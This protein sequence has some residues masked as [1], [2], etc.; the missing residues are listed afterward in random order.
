MSDTHNEPAAKT[1]ELSRFYPPRLIP[2]ETDEGGA[3]IAVRVRRMRR[4]EF[5]RVFA[6]EWAGLDDE[7][8][9]SLR[10]IYRKPDTDERERLD[11]GTGAYVVPD[12]VIRERRL[13][14]MSADEREAF[15]KLEAREAEEAA[16][17][18]ARAVETYVEVAPALP[19]GTRQRVIID[20]REIRTGADLVDVFGGSLPILSALAGLVRQEHQIAPDEKKGWRSRSGS[21]IGSEPNRPAS[22]GSPAET[23]GDAA[24]AASVASANAGA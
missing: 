12:A 8:R 9:E 3:Q 14:E 2:V 4:G 17:I 19:D 1:V 23:A 20:G 5:V 15:R 13:A 16:E 18:A 10:A 7:H 6:V 22:G 21:S 11:N 24:S